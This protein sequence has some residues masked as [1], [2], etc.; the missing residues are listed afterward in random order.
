MTENRGNYW[1]QK[2]AGPQEKSVP[3]RRVGAGQGAKEELSNREHSH[4]IG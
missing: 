2:C 4:D 3:G 1:R